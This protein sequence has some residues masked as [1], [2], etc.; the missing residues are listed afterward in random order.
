MVA[1]EGPP[2]YP[3]ASV[4]LRAG[5][6]FSTTAETSLDAWSVGFRFAVVGMDL[7]YDQSELQAFADYAFGVFSTRHAAVGSGVGTS[8]WLDWTSAARVGTDGKYNPIAQLTA[9]H[10]GTPVQGVGTPMHPWNTAAVVS[11]RTAK[12][13]GYA[14]NGRVYYP[15]L[16]I[17][18]DS[19]TGRL[20]PTTVNLRLGQFKSLIEALNAQAMS[21]WAGC[22]LVV[23]SGVPPGEF[24]KVT[25]IRA[26][27]RLDSIERRESQQPAEWL[28]QVIAQP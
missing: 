23:A 13:R 15:A 12:P 10:D 27:Q 11:L 14:S 26:D 17:P 24:Q 19:S 8:C 7:P 3:H 20:A 2:V 28:S 1:Y 5:G 6:H 16:A 18:L 21:L 22:Q 9:R 25:A 4:I